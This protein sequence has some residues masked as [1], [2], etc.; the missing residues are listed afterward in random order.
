MGMDS[1]YNKAVIRRIAKKNHENS[2]RRDFFTYITIVFS[3]ALMF[4]FILYILGTKEENLR[5]AK[6]ATQVSYKDKVDRTVCY[7]G[8]CKGWKYTFKSFMAR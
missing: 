8:F 2:R 3:T 1:N 4:A 6:E 5:L 7:S